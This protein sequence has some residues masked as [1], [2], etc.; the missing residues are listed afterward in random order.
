MIRVLLLFLLVILLLLLLR[1]LLLLLRHQL[2]IRRIHDRRSKSS[3]SICLY[4]VPVHITV[5]L[6]HF[7]LSRHCRSSVNAGATPP[8]PHPRRGLVTP[9]TRNRYDDRT[10]PAR[11]FLFL[12]SVVFVFLLASYGTQTVVRSPYRALRAR[13]PQGHRGQLLRLEERQVRQGAHQD[14]R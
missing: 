14:P 10:F 13:R 3:D 4:Q 9:I 11:N 6:F 5:Q 8:P 2:G 12:A 1:Q 7:F